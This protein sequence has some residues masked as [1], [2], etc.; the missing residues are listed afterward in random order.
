MNLCHEKSCIGITV[1]TESLLF[2]L[3]PSWLKYSTNFRTHPHVKVPGSLFIYVWY[4]LTLVQILPQKH[5]CIQQISMYWGQITF[6]RCV[7]G[8]LNHSKLHCFHYFCHFF[9]YWVTCGPPPTP[10][11]CYTVHNTPCASGGLGPKALGPKRVRNS[12]LAQW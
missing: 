7:L 4:I 3:H 1:L 2:N 10:P 6:I 11:I 8:P 5:R 9:I 12:G